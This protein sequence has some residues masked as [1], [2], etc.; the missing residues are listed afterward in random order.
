MDTDAAPPGTHAGP[1][2]PSCDALLAAAFPTPAGYH[3]EPVA[4]SKEIVACCDEELTAKGPMTTYRW[5]CWVANDPAFPPD[6]NWASKH[7]MA[8]TPWGPRSLRRDTV[9]Q[10]IV[11][12]LEMH[13]I[14]ARRAWSRAAP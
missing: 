12:G 8:C 7:G 1:A 4:H 11:P 6:P 3:W 13:G 14:P 9:E 2:K 10:V 5:D